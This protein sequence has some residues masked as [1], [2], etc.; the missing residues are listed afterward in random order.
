MAGVQNLPSWSVILTPSVPLCVVYFL[1]LM[2]P[3]FR[4]LA[5]SLYASRIS[6]SAKPMICNAFWK[7]IKIDEIKESGNSNS[8]Y[9]YIF[10]IL[11]RLVYTIINISWITTK[12]S[13]K[14]NSYVSI[15]NTPNPEESIFFINYWHHFEPP[16]HPWPQSLTTDSYPAPSLSLTA[17][18]LS[19]EFLWVTISSESAYIQSSLFLRYSDL[20]HKAMSPNVPVVSINPIIPHLMYCHWHFSTYHWNLREKKVLIRQIMRYINI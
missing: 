4:T 19:K 8:I 13:E 10:F 1:N 2:F 15:K 11:G 16:P 7:G 18:S 14:D 9:L 3:S 20:P 12:S 17:L 5:N 6:S